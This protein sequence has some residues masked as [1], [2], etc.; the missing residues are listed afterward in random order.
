MRFRILRD[1]QALSRQSYLEFDLEA[2]FDGELYADFVLAWLVSHATRFVPR[3]EGRAE[4]CWL[5][6]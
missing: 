4:T 2:M 1:S 5:E 3:K 6:E